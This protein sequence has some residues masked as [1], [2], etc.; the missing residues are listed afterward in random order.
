MAKRI[1]RISYESTFGLPHEIAKKYIDIL[2]YKNGEYYYK[3]ITRNELLKK[4]IYKKRVEPSIVH[5]IIEALSDI[6]IPAFP[7]HQMGSDGGFTEIEVGGYEGSSHFRW[8]SYPPDGWERLD[9]VV[10]KIISESNIK[11]T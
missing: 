10:Q 7:K 8:W 5:E 4:E 6:N 9:E 11:Q 2:K 1:L 3:Y